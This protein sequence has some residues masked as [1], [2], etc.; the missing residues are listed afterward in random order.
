MT[1]LIVLPLAFAA[2]A[3]SETGNGQNE[4]GV[5]LT[6]VAIN[7]LAV[8]VVRDADGV[9]FDIDEALASIERIE[10]VMPPGSKVC[11]P[12]KPPAPGA[13]VPYRIACQGPDRLR[14]NGPWVVDLVTGAF[15]PSLAGLELPEGD[16]LRVEVDL[17]RGE[18][19]DGVVTAGSPLDGASLYLAGTFVLDGETERY[20]LS[21]DVHEKVTFVPTD[22]WTLDDQ[23]RLDL[24]LDVGGW[25]EDLPVAA[26][27]ADGETPIVDGVYTLDATRKGCADVSGRIKKAIKEAGKA[28]PGPKP[29]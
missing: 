8:L 7:D 4:Y 19:K 17:K 11:E 20:R 9:A 29:K 1:R 26:C 27:V 14:V 23:Q 10:F 2:C 22:A 16:Y 6:M 25:F 28:A 21:L 3:G 13:V 15:T 24:E 18:V 5:E 12:P